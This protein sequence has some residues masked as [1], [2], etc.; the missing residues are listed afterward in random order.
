[1]KKKKKIDFEKMTK[2]IKS[3]NFLIAACVFVLTISIIGVSYA[4]FFTVKTNTNN[5]TVTTGTL[6][7]SYGGQSSAIQKNN[8]IPLPDEEGLNQGETDTS[9]IYIQNTGTLDSTFTLN[10]GYDM[11]NFETIISNLD[12]D[13]TAILTPLDYVKI[14][15]YEY[16]GINDETL[17]VGPITIADLPLY[18]VNNS[19]SRYN[20][21]AIL[22]DSVGGTTSGNAT[23]TYKVKMWLSDKAIPAASYSY[24]Y[25]NSEIVAEVEN[26]KMNYN[27]S[28]TLS[29]TSGSALGGATISLQNNSL[30]T[31][32][33]DDGS[34]TLNGI[35]PGVYNLDIT[36]N[37]NV[38][39][40]NLT[41][42]EGTGNSLESL[43]ATFSGSPTTS[44][45]N[46]ADTYKTTLSKIV[47]K[48]GFS[49]YAD[50]V[51]FADGTTYNLA[52]TYKFTGGADTN[53]SGLNITLDTENINFTM[54]L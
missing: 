24:F 6:A 32:T 45:Y 20:R 47:N 16:N 11:E 31:T 12:P 7:V 21:Y 19:D 14:A 17:I 48:N 39:S 36:Y 33:G 9:V 34:F 54:T 2:F 46:I 18:S 23:K 40:G 52:P 4:S 41:V 29:D 13:E 49:T 28:G 30:V 8:M 3:K 38:Y 35:Y 10:V 22:F 5:Q 53:V 25:I 37:G 43:G 27:L 50:A 51:S 15:V 1:M 26:A 44:I 42:E